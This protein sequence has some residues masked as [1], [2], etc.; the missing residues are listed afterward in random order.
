MLSHRPL[1]SPLGK[2]EAGPASPGVCW[3]VCAAGTGQIST[4]YGMPMFPAVPGRGGAVAY[5]QLIRCEP[6]QKRDGG[7]SEPPPHSPAG[8][9]SGRPVA[10][11]GCQGQR[12]CCG[13]RP[14]KAGTAGP[15]PGVETRLLS[16]TVEPQPG[17]AC[18][19]VLT[20]QWLLPSLCPAVLYGAR[21][22]MLTSA[23]GLRV[24]L[25]EPTQC[26]NP[27]SCGTQGRCISP[28]GR[29]LPG[30]LA[31]RSCLGNPAKR[32][33]SHRGG[34]GPP[35]GVAALGEGSRAH[36]PQPRIV[37]VQGSLEGACFSH[38]ICAL[39]QKIMKPD[40]AVSLAA[41]HRRVSVLRNRSL[42]LKPLIFRTSL[43]VRFPR[44][45]KPD[46]GAASGLCLISHFVEM[47][48]LVSGS[49]CGTAGGSPACS[50]ALRSGSR[51]DL[52][53]S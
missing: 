48:L 5:S 14:G 8:P 19:F 25:Q 46:V 4:R 51:K 28:A 39:I 23:V 38:F 29:P 17:S 43:R 18:Q 33:W 27:V 42:F 22:R 12:A 40:E 13:R 50:S 6:S 32:E 16:H 24:A 37:N 2:E 45:Q 47:V 52:I 9:C 30:G 21:L 49:H 7:C 26:H 36:P 11:L 44:C 10:L 3:E 34:R 53:L 1:H 31:G 20:V 15:C 41:S 35:G